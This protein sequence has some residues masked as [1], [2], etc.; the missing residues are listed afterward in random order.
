MNKQEFLD[1][2]RRALS[3]IPL[4]EIEERVGFYGEMID[5]R[6]EEGLSEEEAVAAVGDIDDI[7]SQTVSELPLS[8]LVKKKIRQKRSLRAWE[9]VLLA[10]GSPIWLSLLIAVFAVL[11][12]VYAVLWSVVASLW[13]IGAAFAGVFLGGIA[14]GVVYIIYENVF[15]GIAMIGAAL[16]FAG[17]AIF[18]Y[19]GCKA[20]TKGIAILTKK[21]FLGI[22]LLFI[23]NRKERGK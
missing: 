20:A 11:I 7:V 12:S 3:G 14:L 1:A 4:E 21:I 18:W 15:V 10:V 17:I 23:G 22:K 9:I 6:I 5:D 13:A 16:I 19:F 2:L 8:A